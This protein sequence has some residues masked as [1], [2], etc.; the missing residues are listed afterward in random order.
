MS[1][2]LEKQVIGVLMGFKTGTKTAKEVSEKL[3]RLKKSN[4]FLA[5]DYNKKFVALA[6]EKSDVK[7]INK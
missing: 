5:E 6:R 7:D 2:L 4:P 3:E 1:E